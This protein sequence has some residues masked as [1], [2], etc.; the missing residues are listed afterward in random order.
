LILVAIWKAV[1]NDYVITYPNS[2]FH[3][4]TLKDQLQNAL[5]DLKTNTSNG[6]GTKKVVIQSYEVLTQLKA[7]DS[8]ATRNVLKQRKDL[9]LGEEV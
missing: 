3:D 6:K 7:T 8:H 4:D 2:P 5:K 9:L 1:Y